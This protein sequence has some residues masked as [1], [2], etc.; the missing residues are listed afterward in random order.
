MVDKSVRDLPQ[1]VRIRNG[2]IKVISKVGRRK[3]NEYCFTLEEW[4]KA[5]NYPTAN[6]N[7]NYKVLISR[8][9]RETAV[10]DH[11]TQGEMVAERVIDSQIIAIKKAVEKEQNDV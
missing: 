11:S 4:L 3:V 2:L 5:K 10:L 6:E 7:Y 9:F 1:E 8:K